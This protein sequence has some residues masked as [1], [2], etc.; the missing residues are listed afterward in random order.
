VVEI[1]ITR[2]LLLDQRVSGDALGMPKTNP[3]YAALNRRL[4]SVEMNQAL[5][6]ARA[7]GLW[8]LD[9]RWRDVAAMGVLAVVEG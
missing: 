3:R 9:E 4:T 2:L 5:A 8:R 1:E 6:L 7:A